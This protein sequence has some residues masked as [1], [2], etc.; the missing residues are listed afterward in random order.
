MKDR[1]PVTKLEVAI[2]VNKLMEAKKTPESEIYTQAMDG[3]L[4]QIARPG[5]LQLLDALRG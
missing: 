5:G 3:L 4:R 1:E 2:A